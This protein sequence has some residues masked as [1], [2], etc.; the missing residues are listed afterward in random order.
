MTHLALLLAAPLALQSAAPPPAAE[1]TSE[2]GLFARMAVIG[3]SVS[4]GFGLKREA[5]RNVKLAHLIEEVVVAEHGPVHAGGANMMFLNP[6]KLGEKKVKEALATEPTLLFAVDF[7]FWFSYGNVEREDDRFALLEEG[8]A[9]LDRFPCPMLV[10]D[11][12]DMRPALNGVPRM[13]FPQ[14]VPQAATLKK[15]NARLAAWAKERPRVTVVP[16][17]EF[18]RRT[19]AGD[20]IELRGNKWT[21]DDRE[22]MLQPDLLHP[23]VAGTFAVA[24]LAC[25]A[26][27]DA[28]E[29]VKAAAFRWDVEEL[30]ATVVPPP[31]ED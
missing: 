12:P 28:R 21:A 4:D 8:L 11:L 27:V 24:L 3:A 30:T 26:L 2:A 25:D 5:G 18:V 29:D 10:S 23:T 17:A 20:E 31:E 14:Q 9:L 16:L 22:R 1:A 6:Q 19:F 13:I 7:L 15:L